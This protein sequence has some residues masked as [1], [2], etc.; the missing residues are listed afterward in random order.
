MAKISLKL[1]EL[2]D[3]EALRRE[4]TALTAASAGDGS[5][6][7]IRTAALQLLKGRL[8]EGR[9]KT[10]AMLREDGGGNACAERLS[11][12]MDQLI[13]ALYDFAATH[14]YPVKNPS[15]A[16]RMAVVAVGGYG[17]GTLAPGSDIDLLF[18]LPYKQTPW[19]E[20]T[21]EYML[22]MLWDLGL[23]VGHATRNIDECLR[24]SRTDITI[25]TSILEARF[26]WGERKL[27][28]ELMLRFDHE[29]VRTTGPEYVQAKLAER[30]ER[31][32]KAGESRYLVEPN[33]KDGKGGLRDL[34][35]LF[36]IGKY[37]YRV[38]TGEELVEKG[39]FTD[40]EYREFQKAEDF[41]WA[42]RCHMHFLT[43]KAEE[44]L[45]FDIQREI[46]ERLGYTTHPG[47]SAVERFMKHYFLVAKDVGDLTRIFCAA[48][49]EEQAKHVPGFNRIFL[50][51]QRRKRKLAGTSD[52]IVDNHR[53]NIADDQVFERDPVNLLRLFWFA[54]KHGL[55]FHPDALKLLTRSL[56]LVNKS[57]RRDEEANRLFLDIL[58]SDRNAELNLRRMN[59]AGL[60][61]RLIPDFG[62]IVAMM[63]FSM[64]H[65]YTVDEHL[66]RCIGV[67]AEIERGDGEKVHPL[68]HSL[69]PGLKKSREA[70]YVAVL[71]HDIAKGRPEDH[72]EAGARIARR[73]CPHMGLSPA[74][75]ETVAWLVE[76]H[77]V[78][79]MTA[80]TRDL[81]DRKTIEDF[82]AIVQS[83]ER[84]KMLLI[85]T[86]CDIRGVGPGVWNGWKGQ[87]LRTLYYETELL[88]T[89]GFSEVSRAQRTAASRERLA[90]ALA[91]W[92]DKA[93]K[94]YVGQ[95]YENYLLTVDLPDQLR[96]AE[97][98]RDADAAGKK[99]ATMV[100]THQFEAV[101]EI[102]VL[103]QDHP[104]LLSVIAGACAG[105]GGN[106][107]DAQIFTT[108]DGR[109][110][111]T[112]LISREFDRD[113][114]E[115]RR[116]ER[117]GRLI[118]DVLSGKSWLPEMIEKRTKPRRG[119]K[120]F[121]I[122]PRA[123]IRNA[124]SNR[125]SVI[126]VEGLD[127][128]GL[129]SE[130]TRTLSDL[131]LDIASAHITT[132]GEKVIDTFYV[133]DLTGQKIDSPARIAT[134]RNRLI[135]TLE[136]AAPERGG[137][138]KAA[139]E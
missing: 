94:R 88:L 93:R 72:S 87:L 131:S 25:R 86:V 16:E 29:V 106:I 127:R 8:A 7:I 126:E 1:H 116:A 111:D 28:E 31:H 56:G 123:E 95:H 35:T 5:S 33:V 100:K 112:I 70:L 38:R 109:A 24:L 101:T 21:V 46:A 117:V 83:V 45:H 75:T 20:Q 91:D 50:T 47:L 14:V 84:L 6:A 19:G 52:F 107:V 132:F 67:L 74:D 81:N 65:H 44:R 63:Q 32:A 34:Q 11:H 119:S 55:E 125:F 129:L 39:V 96:H 99:L 103:A 102:T 79:S 64:Y 9:R 10:E 40:A 41:L 13:R 53:I 80:Q 108:S 134:I 122:P 121:K 137:R 22:Y 26:L 18:L 110:L 124:L 43:G 97:F 17:R 57:L 128:P 139:A 42:V 61:G 30:D 51:F 77:L 69:M 12:V 89:G 60:L 58:T 104:R 54:D 82:A 76:N 62:K 92:P 66:I 36:W 130:I 48:L 113:E 73:I 118:E 138:A 135:A 3:G 133:T 49:E 27:Y 4:M 71:L 115:R 136:G 120:V 2:I 114:D 37:F 59:E 85:L 23:K 68:S 15:S 105:A 78:M 98:I 90:E